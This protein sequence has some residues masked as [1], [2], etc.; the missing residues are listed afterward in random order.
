MPFSA[1]RLNNAEPILIIGKRLLQ[2]VLTMGSTDY[3]APVRLWV[4]PHSLLRTENGEWDKE[5]GRP[6]GSRSFL[7]EQ[8]PKPS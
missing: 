5:L 4:K 8:T 7:L 2:V 3:C 1:N 6:S